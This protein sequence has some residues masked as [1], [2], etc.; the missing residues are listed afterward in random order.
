[1]VEQSEIVFKV[2]PN[3]SNGKVVIESSLSL[4]KE[5]YFLNYTF[6]RLINTGVLNGK[7]DLI[8]INA[9]TGIYYLKIRDEILKVQ[10]VN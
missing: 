2:S 1:M 8:Q 9:G 10:V 7:E 5:A 4:A 6:G 3:P